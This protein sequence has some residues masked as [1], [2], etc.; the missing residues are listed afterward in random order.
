MR[1]HHAKHVSWLHHTEHLGLAPC[2]V[3]LGL[4]QVWPWFAATTAGRA[5]AEPQGGSAFPMDK[6]DPRVPGAHHPR[7]GGGG[8][9]QVIQALGGHGRNV[10]IYVGLI[11][12]VFVSLERQ[13]T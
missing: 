4:L 5:H 9:R 11:W 10:R 3:R 1:V 13:M 8:H 2:D 12:V 6:A 7:G